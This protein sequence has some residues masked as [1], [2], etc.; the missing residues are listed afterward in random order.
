M[1]SNNYKKYIYKKKKF[2][3]NGAV[4]YNKYNLLMNANSSWL[5]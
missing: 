5:K 2:I 3:I 1:S 4:N